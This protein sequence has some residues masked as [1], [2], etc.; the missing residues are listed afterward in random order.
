MQLREKSI[1]TLHTGYT[2]E[3]LQAVC[4]VG[5][6]P[7]D[8]G[9]FPLTN[10]SDFARQGLG[11]KNLEVHFVRAILIITRDRCGIRAASTCIRIPR[12]VDFAQPPPCAKPLFLVKRTGRGR[13][14]SRSIRPTS[15]DC[16]PESYSAPHHGRDS[17]HAGEPS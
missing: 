14:R 4:G 12:F 5:S 6:G 17:R 15:A 16:L 8:A 2:Y 11:N 3:G 7:R 10:Y 13:R 1:F 9:P